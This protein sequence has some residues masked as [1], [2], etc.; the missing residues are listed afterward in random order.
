MSL[1]EN[2]K[3]DKSD[4]INIINQPSCVEEFSVNSNIISNRDETNIVN[5]TISNLI[6]T[7]RLSESL[8]NE[9]K[10]RS[11]K[12]S[13]ENDITNSLPGTSANYDV[14]FDNESESLRKKAKEQNIQIEECRN[15]LVNS[16]TPQN[17]GLS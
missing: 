2:G 16:P 6:E 13:K 10:L 14:F 4:E 7:S 5:K 15:G 1:N 9:F 3:S 11:L 12:R 17:Q 8:E